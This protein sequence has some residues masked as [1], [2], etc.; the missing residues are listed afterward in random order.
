MNRI[1]VFYIGFLVLL[2]GIN[3]VTFFGCDSGTGPMAPGTP[4]SFS[5]DILPIF[6]QSCNV[7]GCHNSTDKQAGIDLTTWH[8]LMVN[9]SNFGAEI[10]PYN[11]KW[12]HMMQHINRVDTNISPFSEPLMPKELRPYTTGQPLSRDKIEL[13]MNWINQGAKNDYGEVAFSNI[14]N[15]A[16]IT[17]QASDILAVVDLDNMHLVRLLNVGGRDNA[18]HPLDSPHI[19][20]ADNQGRYFYVSLIAE[21]YI[22]KYDAVTYERVGRMFAGLSP[23][24]IVISNDGTKGWF[25][26]FDATLSEKHIKEFNTETMTIS[27][28]IEEFR[29]T[30]PHG[31]RL[32]HDGSKLIAATQGSEFLYIINTSDNQITDIVGVDPTVPP[33]GNGTSSFLPYQTAI[34][35]DD[36]FVFVSCSASND[37]RVFDMNTRTFTHVIPVGLKPLS[38]DISPDGRWCYVPNRNSNSVTVIDV[39]TMSVFATIS[40]IGAQPHQLDFTEDGHYA[41]ITC[42]SVSGTFVHH[43]PVGS[44]KPGTT[45]VVDVWGGHVKVK[46]IEMASFPAGISITPGKGN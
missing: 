21:G 29:M 11:A 44:S 16:F 23:A 5:G 26:N 43:P 25:T 27:H 4:V 6:E 18:T 36:R 13:I 30:K 37:V 28:V 31:L 9:G 17:N 2:L 1:I 10:I 33:N 7:P 20:I 14:T 19:V 12:S 3:A 40:N 32:T 45:C 38:L 15:K 24:H 35:P 42:E 34:T 46:D 41:Y 8:S 39:N 22:E